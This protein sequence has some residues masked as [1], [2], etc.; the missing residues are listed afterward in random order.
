MHNL[1]I[2]ELTMAEHKRMIAANANV[3]DPWARLGGNFLGAAYG[4]E[5][6]G[7]AFEE[8]AESELEDLRD[9]IIEQERE[10]R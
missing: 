2:V 5:L 7:K 10:G 1:N 9:G 8:F 4:V 3:G 6:S